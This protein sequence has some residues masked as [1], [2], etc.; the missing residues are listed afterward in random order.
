MSDRAAPSETSAGHDPWEFTP[1]EG[2]PTNKVEKRIE[3]L[4]RRTGNAQK[5]LMAKYPPGRQQEEFLDSL[6][7][8]L[9]PRQDL[10][11][12]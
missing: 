5:Y 7:H 8:L 12:G 11:M 9:P 1:G 6:L 2:G 4:L 10:G 3:A